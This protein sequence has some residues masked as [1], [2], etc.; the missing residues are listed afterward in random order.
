MTITDTIKTIPLRAA[1]VS[2]EPDAGPLI[3]VTLPVTWDDAAARALLELSL[4]QAPLGLGDAISPWLSSIESSTGN[5]EEDRAKGAQRSVAFLELLLQ[6]RVAPM[7]PFWQG[8][9]DRQ[10]GFVINVAAFCHSGIFDGHGFVAALRLICE[11]LRDL[12]ACI[13]LQL[14]EELPL[15]DLP[16]DVAPFSSPQVSPRPLHAGT[17]LLTNLDAALAA[18]GF[19]YDSTDGRDAAC[20]IC[21]MATSIARQDAGPVP[22]P[23]ASCPIPALTEIGEQIRDEVDHA[24]T[25]L[26]SRPIVETGFSTP[27]PIDCIL[28]VEA[29]GFAP[30]FS[31]LTDSGSL[32]EST[33]ARLGHRGFTPETA[34]AAALYGQTPLPQ[35]SAGAHL[36]MHRALAGF[37]DRMPA[38]PDPSLHLTPRSRLER[39]QRRGLPKRLNGVSLRTAIGGQ[40]LYLRTGEFDDGSLGEVTI[41]TARGNSMVKGL[42]ESF[43]QAVSIGLQYGVPLETFVEQFAYGRYGVGGTVEGDST[44]HYATS[45]TDY[46]FRNLAETYLGTSLPDAAPEAE[47]DAM[48]SDDPF[49]PFAA[50]RKSS[51]NVSAQNPYPSLKIVS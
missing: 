6:R 45:I 13:T 4:T 32:R 37:V 17:V 29:C 43:N 30:V 23:P 21:W 49:L 25:A 15:F 14:N 5:A 1:R 46:V 41:S 36:T 27:G 34:L 47:T 9:N 10:A 8:Q 31:T 18:L 28:G 51:R 26:P 22:L 19:L 44:T 40:R 7:A 2:V 12:S 24:D 50:E 20:Y 39:G 38:R 33:L 35:P 16:P 3:T 42:I 11:T 48:T